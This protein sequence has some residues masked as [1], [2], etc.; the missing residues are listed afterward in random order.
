MPYL[1]RNITFNML[2]PSVLFLKFSSYL[3][4]LKIIVLSFKCSC[5]HFLPTPPPPHPNHQCFFIFHK[6]S[7]FK[8]ISLVW[9]SL[10]KIIKT[11]L[12]YR[13]QWHHIC[14][15]K[16]RL[17][18]YLCLWGVKCLHSNRMNS[19]TFIKCDVLEFTWEIMYTHLK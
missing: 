1:A 14:S 3:A 9:F 10:S 2:F 6:T 18:G 8:M 7:T 15:H 16:H 13:V 5:L 12:E 17:N 11:K 19:G 4:F